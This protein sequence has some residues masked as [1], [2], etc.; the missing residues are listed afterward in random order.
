MNLRDIHPR[1]SG[2]G[3]IEAGVL[4]RLA[5]LALVPIRDLAVAAPLKLDSSSGSNPDRPAIRDL[6]VAAPLKLRVLA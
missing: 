1:P 4:Q 6:A 3:P 2:R 5:E